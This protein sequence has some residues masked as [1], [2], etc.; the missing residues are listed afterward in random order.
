MY[1]KS[2][3]WEKYIPFFEERGWKCVTTTLRHHNIEAGQ[4]P[5]PELATTSL[6]DYVTDLEAEISALDE[7]PVIMGHSMGG[8]LAQMLAARGLARAAVLLTPAAPAGVLALA[9]SV[10][11]CFAD[12]MTTWAFWRKSFHPTFESAQWA[13]LEGFPAE[14]QR[15]VWERLVYESGRAIF[16]IGMWPID[17]RHAAR[18]DPG[19]ITCP[20]LVISGGRD[21]ATPASVVRK[22]A[23]RYGSLATY[24]NFED[25]AHWV[26]AQKGWE[27]VAE[28]VAG[29]L[30]SLDH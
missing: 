4:P 29:W 17:G 25:D 24:R 9:P 16:E 10:L 30:V 22:V 2:W 15:G 28:A 13:F 7:T 27:N 6:L 20:L 19:E 5:P 26:L 11:K 21:R 23:A 3:V 8:L 1:C 18:V 12:V 14:E